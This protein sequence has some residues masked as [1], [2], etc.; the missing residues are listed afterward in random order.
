[1]NRRLISVFVAVVF[2]A[3]LIAFLV[4][5]HQMEATLRRDAEVFSRIYAN[6]FQG[7]SSEDPFRMGQALFE[8]TEQARRLQIP[9]VLTDLQGN[10]TSAANLPFGEFD[11]G[12]P[13]SVQRTRRYVRQLDARN[14]PFRAPEFNLAIHFGEPRFLRQL[15]WVPWLTAAVLIVAVG[16]GGWLIYTSF[17]GERERIWSAM[18]R[19]SA[20]QMGTPLSSLVGWLEQLEGRAGA[21]AAAATAGDEAGFGL[22]E[23]M[24]TDVGRLL[25]VSRRFEL[26]GRSPALEAIRVDDVLRRLEDYFSVRL[27]TLGSAVDFRIDV[28]PDSPAVLGNAT[29]LEWAFENLVK[30]SLDALAG[31]PGEIAITFVET[32]GDRA[33]YRVSDTGPGVDPSVRKR[34]FEIGVTTKERGWGVGLSLTRRILED[35]HDG[36]IE[37]EPTAEGTT[38]RVELPVADEADD[39][40]SAA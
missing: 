4:Y 21:G 2:A 15:R 11:R 6:A 34:L 38:F 27:P 35:M 19:E 8:I 39:E 28:P 17:Q 33:V 25:K 31:H 18:A 10:P 37:L 32:R 13:A 29:L 20:H 22:V 30:N 40:E 1:M 5:A 12:D 16:G 9:I 26:I 23:E 36:S 14:E 24:K 3:V 7:A